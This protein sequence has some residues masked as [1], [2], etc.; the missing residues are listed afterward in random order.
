MMKYVQLWQSGPLGDEIITR[1]LWVYSRYSKCFEI[2]VA[3]LVLIINV[4][5]FE[6]NHNPLFM[7]LWPICSLDHNESTIISIQKCQLKF[8]CHFLQL[9]TKNLL[10]DTFPLVKIHK[11]QKYLHNLCQFLERYTYIS[12]SNYLMSNLSV[13]SH[14]I[15][16]RSAKLLVTIMAKILVLK[17]DFAVESLFAFL[18][19]KRIGLQ[20]PLQMGHYS[21]LKGDICC[22]QNSNVKK[23]LEIRGKM[24]EE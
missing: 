13:L 5:F 16:E 4:Q 6:F 1:I 12:S 17:P 9:N 21:T 18:W 24:A 2:P 20:V 3:R 19:S 14:P 23:S 7:P 15:L 10:C 22:L 11:K 8:T